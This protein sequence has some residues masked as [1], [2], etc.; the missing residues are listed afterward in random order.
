MP[1]VEYA[2]P[3]NTENAAPPH[4]YCTHGRGLSDTTTTTTHNNNN[5]YSSLK[6]G[7]DTLE[8]VHIHTHTY[9]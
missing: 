2:P 9:V 6:G 3:H 5:S 4:M 8:R 1:P 7:P